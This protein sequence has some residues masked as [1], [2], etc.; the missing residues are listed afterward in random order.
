MNFR[1]DDR[2]WMVGPLC[3]PPVNNANDDKRNDDVTGRAIPDAP[4]ASRQLETR[5]RIRLP[6]AL[7]LSPGHDVRDVR[8]TYETCALG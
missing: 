7:R 6:S 8:G 4:R 5:S 1:R 2:A 3:P